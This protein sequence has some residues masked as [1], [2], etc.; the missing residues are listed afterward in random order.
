[1]RQSLLSRLAVAL[2]LAGTLLFPPPTHAQK[3]DRVK[4]E[5]YDGVEL[6]G[7]FYPSAKGANAITVMLLHN[8]NGKSTQDGWDR[9]AKALQAEG[10]AVLSFDFRGHGD[11]TNI[12]QPKVFWTEMRNRLVKGFNPQKLK[13]TI[14]TTDYTQNYY[15]M[16]VNDITAAKMFLDR[17]N[18]AG[19]CNS[20][21]LIL[22]GAGDGATLGA[23]WLASEMSRYQIVGNVGLGVPKLDSKPEGQSV[24]ACVWLSMTPSL[25]NKRNVDPGP[26]LTISGKVNKVPMMFYYGERDSKAENF[27][28]TWAGKL[29]GDD[30]ITKVFTLSKA[31]PKVNLAGREL[32]KNDLKTIELIT[33]SLGKL[34]KNA[35]L[36][37][38]SKIEFETKGF[39]WQIA[40]RRV[41]FKPA[42]EKTPYRV[43]TEL[44]GAQ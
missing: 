1:M 14:S 18:D 39:M 32:L 40:R 4:F 9:L 38:W 35:N 7:S 11:S 15:P 19:N 31:I 6:H 17:R 20:R 2:P 42:K 37:D 36:T 44:L 16:L 41:V 43:P 8:I 12:A 28:K 25:G 27:A 13:D 22:I 30:K 33:T 21:N 3:P 10:F 24:I 26:W 34:Q 23:L 5:T 29:K